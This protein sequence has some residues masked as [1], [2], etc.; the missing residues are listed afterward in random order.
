MLGVLWDPIFMKHD[1]GG[2]PEGPQRLE[3]VRKAL[4]KLPLEKRLGLTPR[5]ATLQELALV[6]EENYIHFV[7]E[8]IES[9]AQRL[10]VETPVSLHSFDAASMA[11][12]GSIDG[13]NDLLD[14]KM[15]QAFFAVRPPGHH[16]EADKAYGFCLFNNVA[17]GARHLIVNRGVSKVAIF[18]FDVHHG[19]GTQ[20]AFYEDPSVFYASVHQW[21]LF[22]GSGM[23]GEL[24]N[25]MARGTTLNMP[26]PAGAGNNEYRE[27]TL[28]FADEMDWFKPDVLLISAG[29]DAHWADFLAGHEMDEDGYEEIA[30]LVKQIA[31]TFCQGKV[32]V[33]LEG[34]YNEKALEKS[35]R[36]FLETLIAD[37]D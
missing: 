3:A 7:Q 1:T 4:E 23:P 37:N 9:G 2:H 16:A 27:A 32:G 18:D 14:G 29:F 6:H 22:P 35:S 21:P 19:N 25:G 36:R 8:R 26:Y 5:L 24:G 10:D 20:N 17:V 13:L 12:G 28:R 15:D 34:G 31:D 11:V 30:R 33:Y